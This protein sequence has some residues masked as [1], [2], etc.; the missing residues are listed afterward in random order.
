MVQYSIVEEI[1]EK[2]HCEIMSFYRILNF[3]IKY[4][5]RR[6]ILLGKLL[7][8]YIYIWVLN[9]IISCDIFHVYYE[10]HEKSNQSI[11]LSWTML[12]N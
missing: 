2:K 6:R 11:P 12:I 4:N 7:N 9:C 10:Q 8:I 5:Y 3:S 1:L